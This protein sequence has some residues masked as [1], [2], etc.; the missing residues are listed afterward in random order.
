MKNI[1]HSFGPLY[2]FSLCFLGGFAGG[3]FGS[4]GGI[5]LLLILKKYY[6]NKKEIYPT[7]ILMTLFS[8]AVNSVFYSRAQDMTSASPV[9]FIAGIAGA[10]FGCFFFCKFKQKFLS[11]GFAVLTV[12]CGVLMIF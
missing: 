5:I 9:Y 2:L 1:A 11:L 3:F 6:G 7:V 4:G 12:L 8:S 10:V